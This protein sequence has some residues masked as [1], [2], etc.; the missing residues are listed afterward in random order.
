M[1]AP[2][3]AFSP[4]TPWQKELEESFAFVE[5]IDQQATIDEVKQDMEK[6]NPMDRIVCGD[7][8]YGKTEIAVRA[9]FKAVQD[10]KQVAILVPTTLLVQQHFTTFSN[11]YAGFPIKIAALS[12]FNTPRESKEVVAGLKSGVIDVVI[13]THRL[14]SKDI[15][16]ANLGLLVVDE[17]QRFGV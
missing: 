12:R 7:V 11:R 16:F 15:E 3:F 5:T 4:D 10:S 8:G 13:G 17:E 14:L 9:A 1:S 6:P 2:G